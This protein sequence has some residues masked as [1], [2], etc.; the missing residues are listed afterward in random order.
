[1]PIGA[2]SLLIF[3]M[4]E[5]LAR[6]RMQAACHG[7]D[8]RNPAEFLDCRMDPRALAWRPSVAIVPVRCKR[9]TRRPNSVDRLTAAAGDGVAGATAP[10]ED[11]RISR[12][13]GPSSRA[14]S[15]AY[16][17]P[18]AGG[19][20]A[21]CGRLR[22][23]WRMPWRTAWRLGAPCK[24]HAFARSVPAQVR[25]RLLCG[26]AQHPPKTPCTPGARVRESAKA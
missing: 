20:A 19:V 21:V 15:A 11:A 25:W 8:V 3:V 13:N 5:P 24:I 10:A 23:S 22:R 2:V 14:P 6:R 17:R 4:I 26:S 9:V 1:V 12:G 16:G 18:I 7:S